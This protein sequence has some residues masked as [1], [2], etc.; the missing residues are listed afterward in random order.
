MR[1][2]M[3]KDK[4]IKNKKNEK[5][6][7][8]NILNTKG[9]K[10]NTSNYSNK[11]NKKKRIKKRKKNNN[12]S[13]SMTEVVIFMF[14]SIVFGI[15]IGYIV[16][17]SSSSL[18]SIRAYP[19]LNEIVKTYI[20]IKKN[21][22]KDID[23]KEFANAAIKGMI[24]YLDDPNSNYMDGSSTDDF[25]GSISGYYVG[26]GITLSFEEEYNKIIS[27]NKDGPADKAGLKVGD[28]ILSINGNDCHNVFGNDLSK[29]IGSAVGTKIKVK[30]KREE[31]EKSFIVVSERIEVENVSSKTFVSDNKNIGYIKINI[32]STDIY[33]HFKKSL[34]E[35]EDNNIKYLLIDLRN[36]PG[37][38]LSETKKILDLF[39]RKNTVLYKTDDGKTTKKIMDSSTESRSIPVMIIAN[40]STASSSEVLIS[41]FKENYKNVL[42]VG[43]KTYGKGTVQKSQ[44]L[45]SGTSIK[46]TIERW[47]TPS[48]KSVDGKGIE[49]DYEV[50]LDLEYVRNPSDENDNQLQ[51]ALDKIKESIG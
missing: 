10:V 21:Y 12:T 17:Y 35:L 26:I 6:K 38:H 42:V 33:K 2:I 49:P 24:D 22:Y 14:A 18:N 40:G 47:L 45:I 23:D 1:I 48:G 37:G 5:D 19:E 32:F 30:V 27:V 41:C 46:Y 31:E 7:I 34:E 16:T 15:I 25:N 28:I 11:K 29:F 43:S 4:N 36:N 20:S 44:S 13:F 39:F 50:P 51:Y 9:S 3:N 8:I